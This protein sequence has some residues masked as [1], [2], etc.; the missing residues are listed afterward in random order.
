MTAKTSVIDHWNP[1]GVYSNCSC[2]PTTLKAS[3]LEVAVEYSEM[4]G[5][6][7]LHVFGGS[8]EMEECISNAQPA[9]CSG[10]YLDQS[11]EQERDTTIYAAGAA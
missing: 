9:N 3:A 5:V 1:L 2:L 11:T 7:E 6:F 8:R 4:M 10:A